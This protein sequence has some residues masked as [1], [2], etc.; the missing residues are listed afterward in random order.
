M[1]TRDS[2]IRESAAQAAYYNDSL[3]TIQKAIQKA[4]E[5]IAETDKEIIRLNNETRTIE[6]ISAEKK[7]LEQD[8]LS[9]PK[10]KIE[11]EREVERLKLVEKAKV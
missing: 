6:E 3:Q 11:L 10:K 5:R 8:I 9:N 7:K 1:T 2:I 4:D